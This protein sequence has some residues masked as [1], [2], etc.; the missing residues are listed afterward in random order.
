M[1]FLIRDKS[2]FIFDWDGTI[3]DSM[4]IKIKN[5]GKVFQDKYGINYIEAENHYKKYSGLPRY[6]IFE[7]LLKIY[8]IKYNKND[9]D[10]I[11]N[12]LSKLNK[13][14]LLKAFL[15]EDSYY[16]LK[17]LIKINKNICISSS[18]PQLELNYFF[19]NKLPKN[20]QK[21]VKF[22]LG[23]N[24][25]FS[26][27]PDHI[28]FLQEKFNYNKKDFVMIGDDEADIKLAKLADIDSIYINRNLEINNVK[29]NNVSSLCEVIKC[30]N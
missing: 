9:L 11:S 8:S 18:V 25:N 5:F 24:T 17:H 16:L 3:L 1:D 4:P 7:E 15:F 30:L 6:K 26:K 23:S 19:R 12:N 22:V 13:K 28:N 29:Y 27:G 14:F 10:S 2:I 20:I 21:K